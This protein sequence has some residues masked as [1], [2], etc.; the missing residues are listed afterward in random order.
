MQKAEIN[1]Y[2]VGYCK[3]PEFM[4]KRGGSFKSVKF[5]AMV[6]LIETK[7][8]RM[9]FDTGY[10]KYFF[11]VTKQ[12]PEKLYA[13]TTPVTLDKSLIDIL[14]KDHGVDS[15][16]ISHFHADHIGGLRDFPDIR[17]YCSKEAY[18]EAFS[19]KSRFF[20]TRKGILPKL[21][22][23]D[24]RQR[25][26]FIEDLEEVILPERYLPF[27]KAYLIED[28]VYAVALPGHASGQFGL[29]ADDTF[30]VSDAIWDIEAITKGLKP[31]II[32]NIIFQDVKQ[33]YQTI[34]KLTQLYKNNPE[35]KIVPTHCLKTYE[36]YKL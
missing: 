19:Y 23:Q 36:K 14:G 3:H 26:V 35:I 32:T 33:Y 25:M 2:S 34:D 1:L 4:V 7:K 18:Q 10:G 11:D 22:P 31:N 29:I 16:F 13:L 5:H 24:L 30:F 6:A 9:L 8:S 12:F 21:L 28:S 15:I 20:K 27:K 17:I